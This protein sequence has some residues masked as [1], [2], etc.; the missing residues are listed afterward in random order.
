MLKEGI[1]LLC[2]GNQLLLITLEFLNK[3]R[4]NNREKEQ[5][6]QRSSVEATGTGKLSATEDK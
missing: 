1:D 3:L 6:E 5:L 4:N 2:I